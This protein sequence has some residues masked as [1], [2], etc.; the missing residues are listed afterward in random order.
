MV[1][2]YLTERNPVL[3]CIQFFNVSKQNSMFLGLKIPICWVLNICYART[4]RNQ[5]DSIF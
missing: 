4:W 3:S 2:I 5:I 1:F